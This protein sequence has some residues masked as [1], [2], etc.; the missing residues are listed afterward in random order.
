MY[1]LGVPFTMVIDD[2]LPFNELGENNFAYSGNMNF[3]VPLVEKAYA[4]LNGNYQHIAYDTHSDKGYSHIVNDKPG[5][6]VSAFNGSP[7]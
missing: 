6:A 4:K 2:Y 7:F 5:L 3:W 1:A